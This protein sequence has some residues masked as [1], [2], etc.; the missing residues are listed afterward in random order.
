[1][2]LVTRVLELQV[3]FFPI[4]QLRTPRVSNERG[5]RAEYL[6]RL[7]GGWIRFGWRARGILHFL[8]ILDK[9]SRILDFMLPSDPNRLDEYLERLDGG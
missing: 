2:S 5:S 3:G 6:E 4:A 8:H 7:D 1:M 9:I